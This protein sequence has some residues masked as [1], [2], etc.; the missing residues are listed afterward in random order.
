MSG[1]KNSKKKKHSNGHKPLS[2]ENIHAITFEGECK[3]CGG[4]GFIIPVSKNKP[5]ETTRCIPCPKKCSR[6]IL[7]RAANLDTSQPEASLTKDKYHPIIKAA[8]DDI[9]PR[10]AQKQGGFVLLAGPPGIG[11]THIMRA[12]VEAGIAM[13]LSAKIYEAEEILQ[14]IRNSFQ[15]DRPDDSTEQKIMHALAETQVL[16]LD[17]I[18]RIS[19]TEWARAK[20]FNILN[21]RYASSTAYTDLRKITI[22]TT[23][24][25]SENMDHYLASRLADQNSVIHELWDAPD[26]RWLRGTDN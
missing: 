20:I 2:T 13:G 7:R 22:M 12:A 24:D 17:E 1:G 26:I 10:I 9:I 5:N 14:E 18:D 3:V 19:G 23:N 8:V 21:T 4:A 16:C 15:K 11:K 6:D 25:K